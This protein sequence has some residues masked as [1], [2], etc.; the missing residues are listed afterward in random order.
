MARWEPRAAERLQ[1]AALELYLERGFEA[2]TASEIAARAG[3]A[4]RTF[5]RYFADK[6]EVLF[7]GSGQLAEALSDAVA[8]ADPALS[9]LNACLAAGE[10]VGARL[11]E[12]S[13]DA[14]RRRQV[15]EASPELQE[16]ER[17]KMAQ[18]TTAAVEG[19]ARRGVDA[20]RAQLVA[21]IAILIFHTAFARWIDGAGKVAFEDCYREATVELR[22][23]VA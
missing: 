22:A 17:S 5:F 18:L 14:A 12:W 7:A 11:A 15:I 1:K 8:S 10:S 23:A 13:A 19:L 3:L 9:P 20:E 4:R 21:E 6:R 2:V 16:R